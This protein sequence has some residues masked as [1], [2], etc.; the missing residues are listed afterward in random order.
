MAPFSSQEPQDRPPRSVILR[1]DD[2]LKEGL[3]SPHPRSLGQSVTAHLWN[4]P[5]ILLIEDDPHVRTMIQLALELQQFEVFVPANSRDAV[6]CYRDNHQHIAV[7]LL[8]VH[9]NQGN[10]LQTLDALRKVNPKIAACFMAS[11]IGSH[12]R[13]EFRD[14]DAYLLAKP[15]DL[16]HLLDVLQLLAL[17]VPA[18]LLP[19]EQRH[20]T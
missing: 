20:S 10:G 19:T 9:L 7:V 3:A 15:F 6:A 18:H 12:E 17:G 14:R 2:K 4:K 8:E 16:K 11:D 13:Q 5:G 1:A